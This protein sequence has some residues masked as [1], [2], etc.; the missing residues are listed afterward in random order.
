MVGRGCIR[1]E[2]QRA[3][4]AARRGAHI[5]VPAEAPGAAAAPL[6][7]HR[8]RGDRRFAPSGPSSEF[9]AAANWLCAP[10]AAGAPAGRIVDELVDRIATTPP[11]TPVRPS[12]AKRLD[13]ASE[14]APLRSAVRRCTAAESSTRASG[15]TGT[16]SSAS[17]PS[18]SASH[19]WPKTRARAAPRALRRASCHPAA[20]SARPR[21]RAAR[22]RAWPPA[23][24]AHRR[25]AARRAAPARAPRRPRDRRRTECRCALAL[26][27]SV[28]LVSSAAPSAGRHARRWGLRRSGRRD[29][30]VARAAPQ[31]RGDDGGERLRDAPGRPT[32]PNSAFTASPA[33]GA[34]KGSTGRR[35]SAAGS[36][37]GASS[38]KRDQCAAEREVVVVDPRRRV[39]GSRR[40]SRRSASAVGCTLSAV[41][42]MGASGVPSSTRSVTAARKMVRLGGEARR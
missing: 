12:A 2:A 39:G 9:K 13:S 28:P 6:H 5:G 34:S 33:R 8:A 7:A 32:S 26:M 23:S 11:F 20:A 25:C 40:S 38:I 16:A 18:E 37:S 27:R 22:A 31:A 42:E 36:A 15:S 41:S 21:A 10:R 1:A 24:R 3:R 4:E 14:R 29:R 30:R 17:A 35:R 19:D